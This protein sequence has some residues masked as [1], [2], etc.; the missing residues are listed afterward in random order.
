MDLGEIFK[1]WY[2]KLLYIHRVEKATH[3][4]TETGYTISDK[5]LLSKIHSLKLLKLNNWKPNSLIQTVVRE[6]SNGNF[7]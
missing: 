7:S 6:D 3:R 5:E 2:P 1:F 4:M